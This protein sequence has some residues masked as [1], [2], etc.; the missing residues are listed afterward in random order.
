MRY[1]RVYIETLGYQLA[2]CVVTTEELEDRLRPVYEKLRIERGQLE[3]IT[4][5]AERRY[6]DRDHRVSQGAAA[7]GIRALE[8][9]SVDIDAIEMLIYAGV[10][11]EDFEP[12][13]AC[14][15]A[16]R[17][18][19]SG[20][21]LGR[22]TLIYDVS[23]ACLGVLNGMLDVANRIELGQIRAG[24]VLSCETAREINDATISGLL[25]EPSMELFKASIATLTGGS[26]AVAVILTDGSF[27]EQGRRR[28]RGA[29]VG[30]APE[31]HT[32]C[33]WGMRPSGGRGRG[34]SE[35][36]SEGRD[37]GPVTRRGTI[38]TG[39][40]E[41]EEMSWRQFA[42][43]DASAVL[44]HGVKLGARTWDAFLV[45]MEWS[46]GAV[47]RTVCH[48]VGSAH[49]DVMLHTLGLASERDFIA[50]DFLGNT[51]TA[52]LPLA[53]ALADER[54]FLRPG[55][56]VALLGIGSGLNCMILG[57]EW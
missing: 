7:A 18:K 56:N 29:V 28:L 37:T 14:H 41:R 42:A 43:T 24:M 38:G 30:A 46:I 4:G 32:L 21:P 44:E 22:S 51:G 15:V 3:H 45:E 8:A 23:N 25:R 52:A 57:V 2:S 47:D 33:R 50:Y 39:T 35:G 27:G 20:Y 54:A 12:A 19:E 9:S 6:W 11:R 31:H 55:Q 36:P 34:P 13:T 53:T 5:I 10:C 40:G 26:A 1:E 48:Q 17:L 16:A 49:R